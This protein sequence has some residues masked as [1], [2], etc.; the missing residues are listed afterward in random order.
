MIFVLSL[1][2][3]FLFFAFFHCL[4]HALF[5]FFSFPFKLPC[6]SITHFP[7]HSSPP[8]FSPD[9]TSHFT[10]YCF[11]YLSQPS[12]LIFPFPS[13]PRNCLSLASTSPASPALG[14]PSLTSHY[15]PVF[16]ANKP[17]LSSDGARC[18][19][20]PNM[21]SQVLSVTGSLSTPRVSKAGDAR[22]YMTKH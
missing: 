20:L 21:L 4:L 18:A 10:L 13:S 19:R 7:I 17:V 11:P 14:R 2:L 6:M 1:I 12:A 16:P 22:E 8:P 15:L 5:T 9:L 3:Y